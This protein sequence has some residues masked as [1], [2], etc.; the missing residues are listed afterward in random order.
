MSKSLIK[1][2][3]RNFSTKN[4][5]IKESHIKFVYHQPVN[6]EISDS[7]CEVIFNYPEKMN[8]IDYEV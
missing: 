5:K 1:M 7:I 6:R 3:L 8:I 4:T 2:K